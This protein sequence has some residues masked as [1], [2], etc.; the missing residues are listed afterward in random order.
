M[1]AYE[2]C[3]P[4]EVEVDGACYTP[5][6]AV[7][8]RLPDVE[9]WEDVGPE[10]DVA[11]EPTPVE[12][13]MVEVGDTI[14]TGVDM[15]I[16]ATDVISDPIPGTEVDPMAVDWSAAAGAFLGTL[17]SGM[18]GTQ[19]QRLVPPLS[20]PTNIATGSGRPYSTASRTGAPCRRRR[21]RR[22][23]T[24]TDQADLAALKAMTGNNDAFKYA[25]IKAVRR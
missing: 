6:S 15:V 14:L 22:L 20:V 18:G 24:P 13:L 23:L 17:A 2:P 19:P 21:R 16:L 11:P 25:I 7:W 1:D 5:G 8:A 10:D 3:L 4:G 9:P 12:D